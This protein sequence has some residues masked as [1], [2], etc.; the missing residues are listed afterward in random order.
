MAA[1]LHDWGLAEAVRAPRYFGIFAIIFIMLLQFH[2]SVHLLLELWAILLYL[3]DNLLSAFAPYITGLIDF[4][5]L[6]VVQERLNLVAIGQDKA[7]DG[8]GGSGIYLLDGVA[9]IITKDATVIWLMTAAGL[10]SGG[11]VDRD[12]TR[13]VNVEHVNWRYFY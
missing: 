2:E 7:F 10:W 11:G 5:L 12:G 13:D 8:V 4:T 1:K 3:N 6:S 9:M